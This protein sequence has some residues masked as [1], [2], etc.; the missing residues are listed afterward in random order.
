[1][2][3]EIGIV[4]GSGFYSLLDVYETVEIETRYGKPSDTIAIGELK[5]K[6]VAFLPRHG[7][8]HT[9]PP[10]RVP[11]RANIQ[12][13]SELGVKRIVATAAIGSLKEN[14]APGDFVLFDQ[15]VNMTWGRP[16]TFYGENVV[17]HV[18]MAEPY[19]SDL[20]EIASKELSAMK[21]RHHDK[22]TVVVVN[23]PRFST[24]SESRFFNSQ[25]FEVINMTQYPEAALAREKALCYLG[26]G[27]VTDY[28]VG[29]EGKLDIKPVNAEEVN[30][31]FGMSIGKAKALVSSIISKADAKQG[32]CNCSKSLDSAIVTQ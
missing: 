11:Y 23:G 8:K 15:F 12:A 25:G 20:R 31:V 7:K 14:Y 29:L 27:I 9:I 2:K 30:R 17:A 28:D 6:K 19:C 21:T 16:D 3:A 10:H 4:G 32:R 22:A 24:R 18:G 1:M 26:I 5:G 13:L